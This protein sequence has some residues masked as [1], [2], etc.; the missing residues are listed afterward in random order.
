M[1][2][3][4]NIITSTKTPEGLF[5]RIKR[6]SN[7]IDRTRKYLSILTFGES[8]KKHPWVEKQKYPERSVKL[9]IG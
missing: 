6:E 4:I 9:E 5:F 8:N 2:I 1:S 3:E 7:L